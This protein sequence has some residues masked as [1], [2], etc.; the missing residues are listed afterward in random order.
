MSIEFYSK[1][2]WKGEIKN[3]NRLFKLILPKKVKMVIIEKSYSIL[4]DE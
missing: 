4:K 2:L 3:L 1:K